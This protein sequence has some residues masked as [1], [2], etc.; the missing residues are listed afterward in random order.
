M[1]AE[2]RH[3]LDGLLGAPAPQD[4]DDARYARLGTGRLPLSEGE[5]NALG[6][7]AERFPLFG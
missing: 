4:W 7:L 3:A 6:P 5:R 1:L 2:V